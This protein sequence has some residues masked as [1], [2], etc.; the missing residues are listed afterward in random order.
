MKRVVRIFIPI[1]FLVMIAGSCQQ[2]SSPSSYL[3]EEGKVP[4]QDGA[5]IHYK[6]YGAGEYPLFFVHGWCTHMGYWD[7]QIPAFAMNYKVITI[8]LAGHGKSGKERQDWTMEAYG[9]DIAAVADKLNLKNMILIG[10]SLGGPAILEAARMMPD[11]VIGLV[12]ADTFSDLYM[13]SY[14]EER[15]KLTLESLNDN[16]KAGMR[17]LILRSYFNTDT[18]R[19][20]RAKIMKDM[21]SADPDMALKSLENMLRYDATESFQAINSP[22]RSVNS[23][24]TVESYQIVKENTKSV[25]IEYLDDVG[26][27]IMLEAPL[28][29]NRLLA[30][31][32]S[33]FV[34]ESYK[35]P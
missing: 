26:H 2:N 33:E 20:I 24:M 17:E 4:S 5:T 28:E 8:D 7:N 10:H 15:I 16:F 21:T 35:K 6:V 11:R 18:E 25:W 32:I 31:F 34:T 12:G 1:I 3:R 22:V 9:K 19:K 23:K 30:Q 27:F 13:K 14:P 29:F